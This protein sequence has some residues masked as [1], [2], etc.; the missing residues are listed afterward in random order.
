MPTLS[1]AARPTLTDWRA[2]AA[3]GAA[4]TF[5]ELHGPREEWHRTR[6][7][8]PDFPPAAAN[9]MRRGRERYQYFHPWHFTLSNRELRARIADIREEL[10]EHDSELGRS[11]WAPLLEDMLRL[12]DLRARQFERL[13][14][15]WSVPGVV[16]VLPH[17]PTLAGRRFLLHEVREVLP[18]SLRVIVVRVIAPGAPSAAL[19]AA[20]SF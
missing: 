8:L 18:T 14:T 3:A 15:R 19:S 11:V 10:A 1:A 13:L 16:R 7:V 17:F 12:A 5:R 20:P 6:R 9:T 2:R 4:R